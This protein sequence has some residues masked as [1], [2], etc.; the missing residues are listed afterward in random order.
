MKWQFYRSSAIFKI[1]VYS[2][3]ES[4]T[5]SSSLHLLFLKHSISTKLESFL[6]F[7]KKES[8]LLCFT[9]VHAEL[10]FI[11]WLSVN[12]LITLHYLPSTKQ[13][14]NTVSYQL[15]IQS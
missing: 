4:R 3:M 15:R 12:P 1:S 2:V 9:E 13:L 11:V 7:I 6:F 5:C 10:Q 14:K 8:L